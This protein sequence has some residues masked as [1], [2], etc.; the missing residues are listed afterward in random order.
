ML[1]FV[2][3]AALLTFVAAAFLAWPLLRR[4]AAAATPEDAA[5]AAVYRDQKAEIDADFA[6][7]RLSD[8]ERKAAIDELTR[9]LA[10]DLPAQGASIAHADAKT[11]PWLALGL[12]L[13]LPLLG[14]GLYLKLGTPAALTP[15]T[16]AQRVP[17]QAEMTALVDRLAQRMSANRD[18]LTGWMLLARS[19]GALG[20][21][22]ESAA[23]YAEA[24]RL[25]PND[26]EILVNRANAEAQAA[27][28][29]LAGKPYELAKKALDIEP[30]YAPALAMAA[31]H[32]LRT[33]DLPAARAHLAALLAQI[34]DQSEEKPRI[35]A[36]LAEIDAARKPPAKK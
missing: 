11:R 15:D 1:P 34:P 19:Q 22:A 36:L 12:A 25:A 18:D 28:G 16:Q 27:G 26:P 23:A 5:N 4:K 9:R 6:A 8:T 7:G 2:L 35:A 31:A 14:G 3:A 32:E 30:Q 13:A 24:E 21:Y 29:Q 10:A 33:G 20:R 17:T